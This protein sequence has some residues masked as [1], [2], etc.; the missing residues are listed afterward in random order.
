MKRALGLLVVLLAVACGSTSANDDVP[1]NIDQLKFK[2]MDEVGQP[3]FCD[4]DLY[5]VARAGGEQAGA[6]SAY[7]QIR[8]DS[9]LYDAIVAHEGLPAR[10][11]ALDDAEKLALYR[12][13]KKTRA[14]DL[15]P[16]SSGA[17]AYDYTVDPSFVHV[18]GTVTGDGRLVVITS[19]TQGTRP[20]CPV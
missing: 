9:Q 8:A 19:H 13:Y 15:K 3:A 5:P 18:V 16:N 12:A 17:Y 7:P 20:N 1:L 10:P 6:E 11:S 14:L 2:V 4:P